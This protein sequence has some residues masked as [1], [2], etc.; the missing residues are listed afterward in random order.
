MIRFLRNSV[1]IRESREQ[2]AVATL[3][4]DK[5]VLK[6]AVGTVWSKIPFV[7]QYAR[8]RRMIESVNEV[9]EFDPRDNAR[10]SPPSN[11]SID[12]LCVWAVEIYT[13]AEMDDLRRRLLRFETESRKS[14]IMGRNPRSMLEDL[15]RS[16]IGGYW[17]DLGILVPKGDSRQVWFERREADLPASVSYA[18]MKVLSISPS[19]IGVVV[20]FAFDESFSGRFDE[21][22][23][24]DRISYGVEVQG[25]IIFHSPE[26]QKRE[27]I[28]GIRDE[29]S[30]LATTW[31]RSTLPG[32]FS[33]GLGDGRLPTCELVTLRATE[34]LPAAGQTTYPEDLYLNILG[35]GHDWNTWLD[36]RVPD[37]KFSTRVESESGPGFHSVLAINEQSWA[38]AAIAGYGSEPRGSLVNYATQFMPEVVSSWALWA[39]LVGLTERVNR[40]R[41]STNFRTGRHNSAERILERFHEHIADLS[42][43]A[44]VS[45]DLSQDS[46][47]PRYITRITR[48]FKPAIE[49][50]HPP[51]TNLAATLGDSIKD[52]A[53]RLRVVDQTL[54]DQLSS[55]GSTIAARENVRLQKRVAILTWVMVVLT[56]ASIWSLSNPTWLD[57][58]IK[59]FQ[60]L[61]S[62]VVHL[63]P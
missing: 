18:K 61:V 62:Q 11:E 20:C 53:Q 37:L 42:Y 8:D 22:L 44:A 46:F 45:S 28:S 36:S 5:D 57:S 55:L 24:M 6:K 4:L 35:L 41:N 29:M 1:A 27:S 33:G 63:T 10:T 9:R 49:D 17:V 31:F 38:K 60:K 7:G 51:N 52:Q 23:R 50:W 3:D 30:Q 48:Q 39:L 19:I 15:F 32:V 26:N 43:A 25:G 13:P 56:G 54:L 59:W 12:L 34:P 16:N 21:A 2:G 58:S 14:M 47:P 40:L